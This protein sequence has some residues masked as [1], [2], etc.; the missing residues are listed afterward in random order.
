MD[1]SQVVNIIYGVF[2]LEIHVTY[3]N[4]MIIGQQI[5]CPSS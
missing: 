5:A 1:L 2:Y 3:A 4:F